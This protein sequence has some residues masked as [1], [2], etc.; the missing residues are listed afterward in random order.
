MRLD[1]DLSER[2]FSSIQ[3]MDIGRFA[4]LN[5]LKWI[6][7]FKNVLVGAVGK[8]HMDVEFAIW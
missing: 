1:N 3:T 8:V 6:L 5:G 4:L 7:S 2:T